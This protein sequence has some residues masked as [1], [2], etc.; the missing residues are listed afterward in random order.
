MCQRLFHNI[1]LPR[2]CATCQEPTSAHPYLLSHSMEIRESLCRLW[3]YCENRLAICLYS[4]MLPP[5]QAAAVPVWHGSRVVRLCSHLSVFPPHQSHS[6]EP[7]ETQPDSWKSQQIKLPPL[8]IKFDLSII[9]VLKGS[10]HTGEFNEL[11]KV[12]Q[13]CF[14]HGV[15]SANSLFFQQ[16]N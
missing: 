15:A 12:L 10:S 7:I 8:W 1:A 13:L 6:A 14:V 16:C 3:T 5:K 2:L 11:E 9:Q 4:N